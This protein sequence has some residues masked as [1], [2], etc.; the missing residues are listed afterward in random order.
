[1]KTSGGIFLF[2][3]QLKNFLRV[4]VTVLFCCIISLGVRV[5]SVTR[6]SVWEG[7]RMFFLDSAS[8]QALIKKELSFS[9]LTRVK[10]ECVSFSFQENEGGMSAL[11]KEILKEY[12]AK[13]LFVERTREAVSYYCYTPRWQDGI[14]LNGVFVNLH[15][16][17]SSTQCVIGT[18]IIFGG[19]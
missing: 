12:G 8:S 5:V 7:E 9:E 18:P 14:Y 11:R 1:M 13:V 10:G 15:F 16:A 6:L 17:F 19:F 4:S 3:Y 2:F